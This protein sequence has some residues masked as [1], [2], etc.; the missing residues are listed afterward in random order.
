MEKALVSCDV[1]T[2]DRSAD[3]MKHRKLIHNLGS[4][5]VISLSQV[6]IARLTMFDMSMYND[7]GLHNGRGDNHVPQI[8]VL[9]RV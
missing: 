5:F 6:F 8:T 9:T 2:E 7:T 1:T 4:S 3:E